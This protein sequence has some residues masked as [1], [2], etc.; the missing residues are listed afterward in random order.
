MNKKTASPLNIDSLPQAIRT[1]LIGYAA[2]PVLGGWSS[3]GI[4]LLAHEKKPALFLK[5]AKGDDLAEI[6]AEKD[7]IEWLQNRLTVP[8]L[9]AYAESPE[10]G[11]LLMSAV[12]GIDAATVP[13]RTDEERRR[14]VHLLAT[15]L[16]RVHDVPIAGCPFDMT[17]AVK[18]EAAR[19][20][21]LE[22]SVDESDFEEAHQGKTADSLFQKLLAKRPA[23]EDLVFT[24]GD[25][26]LPNII[27]EGEAVSGF[28]DLGRAGVADLYQDIALAIRSIRHNLG[29]NR[30]FEEQFYDAYGVRK[31]DLAKVEFYILLDEFF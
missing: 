10:G 6:R 18:I 16:R 4:F 12:L 2:T 21:V 26:S 5:M 27:V 31:P 13:V 22:G 30:E 29:D 28:I 23:S 14:L 17:L 11:F 24:H 9:E 7:R 8:V 15:G 3:A 20:N 25:Y 1:R 19:L